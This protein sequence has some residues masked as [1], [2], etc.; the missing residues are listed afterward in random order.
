M[1]SG[2]KGRPYD[3]KVKTHV[4]CEMPDGVKLSNDIYLPDAGGPFPCVFV[5][6]PYGNNAEKKIEYCKEFA[7]AG[8]AV[9]IQDVRGRYDSE[10]DWE[11]FFNERDDSLATQAWIAGQDFCDGNIALY[12]RSY[13]GFCVWMGTFGHHP[14]VKAIIP[15]VALPDPVVN[16]PWQNGA[17]MWNIIEWAFLI[18]GRTNQ[19]I[20]GPNWESL[21]KSKPLNRL[22]EQ[23]GFISKPWR[24]WLEH[25]T[26]DDYWKRICY[27]HRMNELDVPALHICGWYDD[28]G[29]STYNNYPNARKL[30]ANDAARDGQAIIV[31]PWPHATNTKT[32]VHGV[33]FGPEEVIDLERLIIKWLDKHVG[34]KPESWEGQPRARIFLM[35]ENKWH[36]WDDWPH[37][38]AKDVPFYLHSGGKANS[39]YGDGKLST[40][41]PDAEQPDE[42]A[43]DP[44]N[45]A[46]FIYDAASL[47]V[48]GPFDQR[49]VERRDDVLCYTTDELREDLVICGRVMAEIYISSSAEDTDFVAKLCDIHPDGLSRQLCDGNIRVALRNTLEKIE[50]L[51]PGEIAKLS[52]DLWATGIRILKGHKL[53]LEVSSSACPQIDTH[54]NTLA[55]RGSATEIVIAHNKVFHDSEHQSRLILP[56]MEGM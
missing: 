33:D 55:P 13:E 38:D 14:A 28:D 44:A 42:F 29:P 16:V 6:T 54:T 19:E 20:T 22:D 10:G 1:N 40:D 34:G 43:Y 50:P 18:H 2:D 24:E 41:P 39:L 5:R 48:G 37:P 17:V 4:Q 36:E 21:Y 27:M 51:P 30:A 52:V 49:P 15:V 9:V 35:G 11:P 45:P 31:G 3:V 25:E 23:A 53:R 12:G 8:Y 32:T 46:P 7:A 56:V 26:K 47:Q